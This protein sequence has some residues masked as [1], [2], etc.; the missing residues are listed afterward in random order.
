[1]AK[2]RK[3]GCPTN[4][5]DWS[6]FIQD[7]TAVSESWIRIKGLTEMTR[8]TDA[9]TEDGSAATDLWEEP[10]VTKRSGSISLDG[11]K[12][13]DA[14]TG[15][16][17]QGQ[18]MLNDY[19]N[20]GTCDED[21]TLKIVDPYGRAIVIDCIVTGTENS[22]DETEETVSWDL[23][24]VGEAQELSFVQLTSIA[25]KNGETAVTTL[26]KEVGDAGV[27]ITVD[28]TPATASNQRFKIANSNRR[29][30]SVSNVTENGFILTPLAAGTATVKVTS[31]NNGRTASIA[32][33]V[34]EGT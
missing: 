19:A 10:Y 14:A 6:I 32:V 13:I 9:D 23:E 30:V 4:I 24:Q 18:A 29:V 26:S 34:T 2:G 27:V 15:V 22:A 1:M 21:A 8:S 11:K 33:T 31:V 20:A 16:E 12:L 25:L 3:N 17:D 7:K 28:F 5:R